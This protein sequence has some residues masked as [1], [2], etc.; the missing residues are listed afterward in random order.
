MYKKVLV[1][2]D[3]SQ[4]AECV[5]DHVV[6]NAR[7]GNIGEVVLL[8]VVDITR[9]WFKEN[10]ASAKAFDAAQRE[11]TQETKNYLASAKARL[12]KQGISKVSVEIME[13]RPADL[14]SDMATQIG[15]ELIIMATHGRTGV[16][17]WQL[18]SV[19]DRVLHSSK[20]PVLIVRPE[21][22]KM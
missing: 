21:S 16:T 17:K 20:V 14:I 1:P 10:P 18:G 11:A 8:G 15:A 22:C 19:S 7:S 6:T 5:L 9:G 12:A 3:G 13:G 2:L 4:L